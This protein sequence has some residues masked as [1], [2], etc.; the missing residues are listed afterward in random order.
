[1]VLSRVAALA[2]LGVAMF[3]CQC[4]GGEEIIPYV[5]Y[6]SAVVMFA[7]LAYFCI[8]FYRHAR[9]K[10]HRGLAWRQDLFWPKFR[11]WS[12]PWSRSSSMACG[13]RSWKSK[14]TYRVSSSMARPWRCLR[15]GSAGWSPVEYFR[16]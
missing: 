7:V 6:V 15:S 11:R 2:G 1:M 10:G 3:P 9:S 13:A 12:S 5:H 8:E 4:H 16:F 14:R